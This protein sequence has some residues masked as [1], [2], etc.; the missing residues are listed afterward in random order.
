MHDP[1]VEYRQVGLF[2]GGY[3]ALADVSETIARGERVVVCG[4]SG[5]GK[6]SLLQ[7]GRAHV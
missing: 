4:P 7:I 2:Y 3:Q 6:S 5:S 1:I